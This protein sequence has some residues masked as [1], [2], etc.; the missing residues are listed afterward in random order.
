[1]NTVKWIKPNNRDAPE[2][3][4]ISGSNDGTCIV[5]DKNLPFPKKH[6]LSGHESAITVVDA[7]YIDDILTIATCS[8][9]STVKLWQKLP[10]TAEFG[11]FQTI[12]L[13]TG[14]CFAIRFLQL[15]QTNSI[16]LAFAT[17]DDKIHLCSENW[18]NN[19][20]SFTKI[21]SLVG[22][23]DWVRSLDFVVDDKGDVLLAS[24]SQDTF[25]RLWRIS[26]RREE[27]LIQQ[28]AVDELDIDENIELEE[29]IFTIHSKDAGK[30]HFALTLESVLLGH[31]NWVLG[32]HWKV[33]PESK[34]LCLLSSS[35]D[36]TLIIWMFD[37]DSG[38][39]SEKIRVGEVGGN[40]LGFYGGKFSPNGNSIIGH[41]FQG[42][43]HIWTKSKED[44]NLWLP[45]IIIGGHFSEVRDLSWE[46][47]GQFL[48]TLSADQTTR[49]HA[50]WQRENK[51]IVS[52]KF[53]GN[54]FFTKNFNVFCRLGMK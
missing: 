32:V 13:N 36:K 12:S 19:E 17:D 20:R 26:F 54:F 34:K 41:G 35:M 48:Y 40:T 27:Q 25:I 4:F 8:N 47:E 29:R 28:K 2:T 15:P 51:K 9:D 37:E 44:E 46:P 16:L 38:V 53:E 21:E 22:H 10:E 45:G 18:S 3:E 30:F 42:S 24:S 50:P 52:F 5:W 6:I 31:E 39:W 33:L 11:C 23:E 49:I 14:F 7:I 1:V 43:F